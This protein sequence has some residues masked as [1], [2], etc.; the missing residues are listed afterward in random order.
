MLHLNN[1][2]TI[3]EC[4]TSR[5][6]SIYVKWKT[7]AIDLS[8]L[9]L[10]TSAPFWTIWISSS[11]LCVLKYHFLIVCSNKTRVFNGES[12]QFQRQKVKWSAETVRNMCPSIKQNRTWDYRVIH[13]IELARSEQTNCCIK[14]EPY[15]IA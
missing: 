14:L 9:I 12:E 6:D 13:Y 1:I 11:R 7:N 5:I 8:V 10:K 3:I 15:R 4:V 2:Q